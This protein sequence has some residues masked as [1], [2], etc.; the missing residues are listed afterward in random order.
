M[1]GVYMVVGGVLL[2]LSGGTI[3]SLGHILILV[4]FGVIVFTTFFK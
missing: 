3:E 4:G 2:A 1:Y